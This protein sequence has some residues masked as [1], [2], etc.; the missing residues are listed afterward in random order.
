MNV[1]IYIVKDIK[2]WKDVSSHLQDY[3]RSKL[4]PKKWCDFYPRERAIVI[5]CDRLYRA[6]MMENGNW[7]CFDKGSRSTYSSTVTIFI[8]INTQLNSIRDF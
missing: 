1:G 2:R 6:C 3:D 4:I 7:F 5:E 8:D